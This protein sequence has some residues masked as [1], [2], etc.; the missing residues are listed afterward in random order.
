[1]S[2]NISKENKTKNN[3]A[4]SSTSNKKQQPETSTKSQQSKKFKEIQN[5]NMEIA[6]KITENYE[7]SSDE[8]ELDGGKI[9]EKLYKNYSGGNDQLKKTAACLENVLQS[10][11][12]ICLICIGSVRRADAVWSCKFCYCIFHLTCVKRWANDSIALLKDK[13]TEEQ[14]Y[15]NNLG[16]FI[17]KKVKT[18]KWCCPQCRCDYQPQD[19]PTRYECFCGKEVDPSSQDWIVPHS[20][21][22]NCEKPLQP[23]CGH[24]C[25]LL[26]H[27]G[28][29]PPC[30]QTITTSCKCG[31][32]PP[33]SVRCFQKTWTCERK[34]SEVLPCGKHKCDQLCHSAKQCPPCSK[35]SLQKCVCGSEEAMKNCSQRIWHCKKVCNK[36]FSCGLHSCKRVC[37]DGDCGECPLSLPRTC[38]CGKTSKIAP[39][40][41][42]T[43]T[44]EDTCLKRLSCGKHFCTQRCHK[45]DCSLCLIVTKKTCRCGMHEKELP[46]WKTFSCETKCKKIRDCGKHAC[47]KKCCDDQCPPCDKVCGKLLSCK[48]HKCTSVCHD[49]PCYPCKLQSQVKCRCGS[50][51]VTVPCGRERRAR[52]TCMELCRIPS[53]CHHQNKHKCH[54]GDCPSCNQV[55][56][57]KNDTTNCDHLCS[58]RCHAA[59]K[60][61]LKNTSNN[62]FEYKF[63]NYEIKQ[64]PHPKC[65]KLVMVEC[66][67]GHEIAEW[68]CWNSKPTSCHRPCGRK[69]KCGNHKC[70]IACHKVPSMDDNNEQEGCKPCVEGCEFKRPP[71]C[72]HRCK[73]PCHPAPCDPCL[74]QIKATCHCGLTQVYYKCSEFY[75]TDG[76]SDQDIEERQE[77]LKSCGSR[78]IKNYPC[79]HRCAAVCHS[80]PC[81]NPENCRKK[82]KIYCECKRIKIEVSCEKS[83]SKEAIVPCDDICKVMKAETERIKQEEAEKQRLI[84]E[85]RNRIELE[86]FEKRFGK[87]KPRE[88]KVVAQ[89]IETNNNQLKLLIGS[90]IALV[91]AAGITFYLYSS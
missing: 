70:S 18:V 84:E 12:A 54:K 28:P 81:P 22:E 9:L 26:C 65:E 68:P 91:I 3:N 89:E 13:G 82:V 61:P 4:H 30:A 24:R 88:R 73:R 39:C 34:C 67:G 45:G 5:K 23:A 53:K 52:P 42:P 86:Q 76:T 49:G 71:G 36:K 59:V 37:H 33:K 27:P 62:I 75:E 51:I 80:G 29:C 57:L 50:T 20:C 41:E 35:S 85:E 2:S 43:E 48:K 72:V 63:D 11:S 56:G 69:L 7:S 25:L 90:A 16:E 21:G 60:V 44:C 10:G 46:C 55:C 15:Y 38:P 66:I 17:P 78:C 77:K 32:S 8:D 83:R 6:K 19:R 31:K 87:R 1:M 58:A 74:A 14:G 40:N 47:N 79:G 64:M